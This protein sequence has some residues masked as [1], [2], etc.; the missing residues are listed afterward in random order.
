MKHAREDVLGYF[1]GLLRTLS[2]DHGAGGEDITEDTYLLGNM[3]WRSIEVIYLA[4]NMQEHYGQQFPFA[5]FFA[6]VAQRE[7]RDIS[8]GEWVNFIFKHLNGTPALLKQG[9]AT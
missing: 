4:N 8:V 3:N 6:Q 2:E 7:H 1:L 5:E 9:T